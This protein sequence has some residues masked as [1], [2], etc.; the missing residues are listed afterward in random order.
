MTKTEP[1]NENARRWFRGIPPDAQVCVLKIIA[2][3]RAWALCR[4]RLPVA[5]LLATDEQRRAYATQ[6]RESRRA[7]KGGA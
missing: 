5:S 3:F 7:R 2:S 6:Q 4:D 1:F